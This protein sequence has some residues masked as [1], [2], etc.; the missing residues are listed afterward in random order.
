MFPTSSAP[1]KAFTL[2]ELL[3]VIAIMG[4]LASMLF[5]SFSRA[6]EMAR[7]TS[8]SSNMRQLGL[9]MAQYIQ[10]YDER[11]PFAG[12]YQSWA[13]GG[14][15]VA[16]FDDQPISKFTK[17]DN[18]ARESGRRANIEGG[19]LYTYVKS[20]QIFVCPSSRDGRDTGIS[21]SMNCVLGGAGQ[22]SV[23][24]ETD[25][26]MLVDEAFPS[27]AY[28]WATDDAT[29]SDQLTQIHNDGGNLLFADGHV[30]FYPYAR[31]QAG[32][33]ALSETSK[34]MKT[35]KTDQPRFYDSDSSPACTF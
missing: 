15:W 28:F 7:R 24:N 16:G 1:R 31:F 20:T 5:P 30:K 3:V 9:G 19:A 10:D 26:V 11:Y 12:N 14:H 29:A 34:L 35:R 18:Y 27:D 33:N 25:V 13:K 22:N 6:R 32:D 2:I 23:Q 8:C 21:Y 4:I 17:A